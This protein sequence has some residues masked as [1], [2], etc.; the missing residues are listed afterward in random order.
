M[1]LSIH[2]ESISE[3]QCGSGYIDQHGGNTYSGPTEAALAQH[4]KQKTP[5]DGGNF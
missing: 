5:C 4:L 1:N 2:Q 3:D